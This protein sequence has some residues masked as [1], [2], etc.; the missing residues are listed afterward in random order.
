M[1]SMKAKQLTRVKWQEC[2][3]CTSRKQASDIDRELM[4]FNHNGHVFE[5]DDCA[6]SRGSWMSDHSVMGCP[7]REVEMVARSE[8]L[9][10]R[11]LPS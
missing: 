3:F 5:I 9:A 8:V 7:A 2:E 4:R 6:L 10:F 1:W 11:D